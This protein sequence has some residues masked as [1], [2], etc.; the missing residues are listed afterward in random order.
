M[1]FIN[2][3]SENSSRKRIKIISQSPTEIIADIERAD[4]VKEGVV[5]TQINAN[6]FLALKEE[7]RSVL[8]MV[9]SGAGTF[10]TYNGQKQDVVNFDSDP[11]IQ[12]N[13]KLTN[14]ANDIRTYVLSLVYPVGSIYLST[15]S[16]NPSSLFGGQWIAWGQGRVP[17][18]IGSNGETNYQTVEMVGGSENSIASHTH[19]QNSHNHSQNPHYHQIAT[20]DGGYSGNTT[21]FYNGYAKAIGGLENAGNV[22]YVRYANNGGAQLIQNSTA[23]NNAVTATNKSAGQT[24]GNR[25]P[26]ITCYMWKRIS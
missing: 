1:E 11:Q 15:N 17:V 7:I 9:T 25:Q 4:T 14:S 6:T 21:N 19:E 3:N 20:L 13:N 22:T 18:G 23:S 26:F 10:I 12:I 16:T 5:G 8:D 24:G 2:R